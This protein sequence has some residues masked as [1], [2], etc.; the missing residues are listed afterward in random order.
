MGS[1]IFFSYRHTDSQYR[2]IIVI[3]LK[4]QRIV[5]QLKRQLKHQAPPFST[6]A[7]VAP[8]AVLNASAGTVKPQE[9]Q[10]AVSSGHDEELRLELALPVKVPPHPTSQLPECGVTAPESLSNENVEQDQ[11]AQK[12]QVLRVEVHEQV[13]EKNTDL[14]P[15]IPLEVSNHVTVIEI[16]G[17]PTES[18]QLDK[19]ATWK[20]SKVEA[21]LTNE[22]EM[23]LQLMIE[24]H[25]REKIIE[26]LNEAIEKERKSVERLQ[27]LLAETTS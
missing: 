5:T 13:A 20:S 1:K 6:P 22:Q 14:S 12:R 21:P 25:E 19:S 9:S 4:A 2:N 11:E 17:H 18:A 26:Q 24:N 16:G 3:F 7:T 8:A 10:D 15:A 27:E 23:E